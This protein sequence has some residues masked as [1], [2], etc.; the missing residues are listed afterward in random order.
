MSLD[1][2]VIIVSGGSRGIGRAIVLGAVRAGARVV[3]C[4][5]T[6]GAEA[7]SV[8]EEAR[9]AGAGEAVAVQA[10]VADAADV[11]SLFNTTLA[12]FGRIDAVVNNAAVSRANLLT[13][14][15]VT[16]WDEVIRTNLTGAFLVARQAI[17]CFLGS[18]GG[19]IVSVG[20]LSQYGAPGNT[21][22][23]ASKGGMAGLVRTISRQYATSGIRANLVVTGYVD[24]ALSSELP[25]AAKRVLVGACPLR[26]AGTPDEIAAA[27]LFLAGRRSGHLTGTA[28]F[29]SGGLLEVPL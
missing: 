18:G 17:R 1:G 20:T 24:T 23:A 25:D 4:S 29:A 2:S 28:L 14:A 16:E 5:R 12:R 26:R 7:R 15:P 22:Y 21:G 27:V 11:A 6:R 13:L 3:F 10:D 8:E 19:A 9:A